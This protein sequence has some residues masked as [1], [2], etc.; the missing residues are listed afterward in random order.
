MQLTTIGYEGATT[1]DFL[2]TLRVAGV[3]TLVDI[4]EVP[5]SRRAGFSK[6]QLRSLVENAGIRYI[7]LVG[8]GDPKSGRDAA[9]QGRMTEFRQIFARKLKS[10]EAQADL[11]SAV[12]LA[13]Q[14]V[15]CLLCYERQPE[16]C[17]R[18]MVAD[19][20]ADIAGVEVCHLGVRVGLAKHDGDERSGARPGANQGAA[21]RR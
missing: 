5:A 18:S 12:N 1:R 10:A 2:A 7:H 16:F 20:L 13:R 8:L 15:I 4:R 17:H 6:S 21:S 11:Q 19:A 3:T 14:G 9:R